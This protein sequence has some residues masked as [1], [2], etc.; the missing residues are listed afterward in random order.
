MLQIAG[1]GLVLEAQA[2]PP[3]STLSW[4][5]DL[6]AHSVAASSTWVHGFGHVADLLAL[7]IRWKICRCHF[8]F[9]SEHDT[10]AACGPTRVKSVA[11]FLVWSHFE[12]LCIHRPKRP[13]RVWRRLVPYRSAASVSVC[14][15]LMQALINYY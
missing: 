4:L 10:S 14:F 6:G 12:M 2:R 8:Y 5:P 15:S 11:H 7:V 1:A 3:G 9:R 13:P